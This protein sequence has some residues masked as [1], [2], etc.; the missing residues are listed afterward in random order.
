MT[1]LDLSNESISEQSVALE[2]PDE[3]YGNGGGVAV[4]LAASESAA[5]IFWNFPVVGEL[6]RTDA[7]LKGEILVGS[8]PALARH[9]VRYGGAVQVL[10]PQAARDLVKEF[11]LK[12]LGDA[13][14]G[15]E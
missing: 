12:S 15:E 14:V 9:V 7:G 4:S 5:E 13:G 1:E 11:A 3:V 2:L 6:R 10:S 8:L